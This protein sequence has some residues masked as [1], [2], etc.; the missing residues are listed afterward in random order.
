MFQLQLLPYDD[1]MFFMEAILKNFALQFLFT[2][3]LLSLCWHVSNNFLVT[4]SS[5]IAL[6]NSTPSLVGNVLSD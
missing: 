1:G 6:S 5:A 2:G 4:G 3:R